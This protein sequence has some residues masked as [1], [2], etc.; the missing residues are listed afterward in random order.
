MEDCNYTTNIKQSLTRHYESQHL[1]LMKYACNLCDFKS[2]FKYSV[3]AHLNSKIHIHSE[4]P[5][6]IIRIGCTLCEQDVLHEVHSNEGKVKI[7]GDESFKCKVEYCTYTTN[8][9]GSLT[10]HHESQHLQLLKYACNLCEYKSF[11]SRNILIHQN[12]KNS[13]HGDNDSRKVLRIGCTFCD[14]N[15][16]HEKHSNATRRTFNTK[17][18]SFKCKVEGCT[19]TTNIKQSLTRHHENKHLQLLKYACNLCKEKS[20]YA[21]DILRHQNR[22][23]GDDDSRKVLRIGCSFC[24]QNIEHKIHSNDTRER[25][26]RSIKLECDECGLGLFESRKERLKHYKSGLVCVLYIR[27]LCIW[28]GLYL[29]GICIKGIYICCVLSGY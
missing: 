11:E 20:K 7:S 28:E 5:K 16:E 25:N 12:S 1:Q 17:D 6:K 24:D 23:H 9:K 15:I 3:E 14:Q 4:E 21:Q 27:G 10:R 26:G 19:H 18:G 8:R 29:G 2:Y 22:K 13:K